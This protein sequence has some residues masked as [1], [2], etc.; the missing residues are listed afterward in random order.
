MIITLVFTGYSYLQNIDYAAC[1]ELCRQDEKCTA[2]VHGELLPPSTSSV[3]KFFNTE[4]AE[5]TL[6]EATS[7]DPPTKTHLVILE[8]TGNA[9]FSNA[10]LEG[11]PFSEITSSP[12]YDRCTHKCNNTKFFCDAM[13]YEI[14]PLSWEMTCQL[15]SLQDITGIAFSNLSSWVQL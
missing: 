12:L 11:E 7:G 9:R 14:N 1:L 15:Y 4:N 5:L 8:S 6:V 2:V 10:A 3:C 13:S